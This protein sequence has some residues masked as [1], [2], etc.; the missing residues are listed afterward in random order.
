MASIQNGMLAL[1]REL[2]GWTTKYVTS[3]LDFQRDTSDNKQKIRIDAI[4]TNYQAAVSCFV[5]ALN[6]TQF[7]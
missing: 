4:T 5:F 2:Q 6:R 1:Q 7:F 3:E